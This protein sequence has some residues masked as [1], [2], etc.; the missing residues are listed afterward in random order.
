MDIPLP[1]K[2]IFLW[3]RMGDYHRARIH[4]VTR[5]AGIDKVWAGDLGGA[6]LTYGWES[7]VNAGNYFRLSE[8]PVEKVGAFEALKSFRRITKKEKISHVCIAGY[9]RL[10]YVLIIIWSVL[11]GKKILL[12]AE[13]WYPGNN[14]ADRLKGL[15][16]RIFTHVCFLSGEKARD[17]FVKRLHYPSKKIIT[18][19]SVIDNQHFAHSTTEKGIPQQLLCVARFSE[20]KNLKM[21]I[22]AFRK[23]EIAK[24]W[25]LILVGGGPLKQ[26]LVML[27]E[28]S[29]VRL[30]NWLGYSEL[31]KLYHEASCFILPSIFEPW[32]LVVNEAMAAGLPIILSDVVG[33]LPDLLNEGKNGWKFGCRNETELVSVLN[34]LSVTNPEKLNEMGKKSSENISHFTCHTWAESVTAN[35]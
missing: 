17:H 12:F 33:A 9:G 29:S 11:S 6:D 2:Y 7:D 16:L 26:E 14:L 13:S 18:G 19:Y 10:A 32:G 5:I 22:S 24:S 20:E 28:N 27:T 30:I 31:P 23:S 1:N 15:F 8:K 21:L 4:E 25:E 34:E 35:W 3:D